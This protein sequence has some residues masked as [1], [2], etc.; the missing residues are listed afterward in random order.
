[1]GALGIAKQ[2]SISVGLYKPART[3]HRAFHPTA[4]RHFHNHRQLLGQFVKRGD[5]TFDVGANIGNRTQILLSLGAIVAA[6]EPQPICARELRA[7]RDENLTVIQEAVG[8]A[9]GTAQL[10]VK[11]DNVLSSM[12]PDWGAKGQRRQIRRHGDLA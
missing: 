11:A 3:L 4:R 12:V 10:Y 7:L 1:M 2:L 6:F 9:E 8:E 5:L